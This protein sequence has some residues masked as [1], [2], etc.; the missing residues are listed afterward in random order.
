[1][2]GNYGRQFTARRNT[3]EN[4]GSWNVIQRNR[5]GNQTNFQRNGNVQK[6]TG[7]NYGDLRVSELSCRELHQMINYLMKRLGVNEYL[8][9]KKTNP[10]MELP[11]R[12]EILSNANPDLP[13]ITD[14]FNEICEMRSTVQKFLTDLNK[15]L[16]DAIRSQGSESN[17]V[18]KPHKVTNRYGN[19]E[20]RSGWFGEKFNNF[21]HKKIFPDEPQRESENWLAR[22]IKPETIIVAFTEFLFRLRNL[23]GRINHRQN[24]IRDVEILDKF[25]TILETFTQMF[26]R[27]KLLFPMPEM[28]FEQDE[29]D[30]EEDGMED[31]LDS[32]EEELVVEQNE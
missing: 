22:D 15:V 21:A 16:S 3:T 11:Q 25:K 31:E 2:R 4:T 13:H 5:G 1:M 29:E 27:L 7:P 9:F 14:G 19:I 12:V 20:V 17:R 6:Y 30:D 23:V 26:D 28:E 32:S 8:N 24:G 10:E 18:L